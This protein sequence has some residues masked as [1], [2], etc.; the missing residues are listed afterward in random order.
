MSSRGKEIR[1]EVASNVRHCFGTIVS[2]TAQRW[3]VRLDDGVQL[4][5]DR[6]VGCIVAPKVNDRVVVVVGDKEVYVLSVVARE[7]IQDIDL[8]SAGNM[9]LQVPAGSFRVAA[10]DAVNLL[11]NAA[12]SVVSPAFDVKANR[13]AI[14]IKVM[15]VVGESVFANIEQVKT[16][17]KTLDAIY[18]RV[19]EQV[20]NA[21]RFVE[22]V[23]TLHAENVQQN[24]REMYHLRAKNALAY[25]KKLIKMDAD[26]IQLG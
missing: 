6:A 25:A 22:E 15:S 23:D 19:T 18:D 7:G 26:Q 13:G 3:V 4:E 20:K 9:T 17:G 14:A 5:A 8:V 21:F 16:V 24:V 2:E 12:V 11:S 10:K 1:L